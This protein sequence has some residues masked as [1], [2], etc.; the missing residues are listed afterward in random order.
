[1][2][3]SPKRKIDEEGAPYISTRFAPDRAS[4]LFDDSLGYRQACSKTLEVHGVMLALK[5]QVQIG[6]L[7][8]IEADAV[9]LDEYH[10]PGGG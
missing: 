8:D 6:R 2:R 10:A 3:L 4:V 9:V 1:M 7:R 5:E